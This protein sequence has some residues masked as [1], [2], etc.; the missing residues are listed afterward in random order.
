MDKEALIESMSHPE[1]LVDDIEEEI[2]PRIPSGIMVE[3]E[4]ASPVSKIIVKTR[5]LNQEFE[6]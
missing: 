2:E 1:N 4:L 3:I 5:S 6:M